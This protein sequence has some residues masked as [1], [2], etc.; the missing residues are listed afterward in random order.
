MYNR[1]PSKLSYIGQ[2]C[3]PVQTVKTQIKML[4]PCIIIFGV[5]LFSASQ[6]LMLKLHDL[7]QFSKRQMLFFPSFPQKKTRLTF[8]T[9]CLLSNIFTIVCSRVYG[10]CVGWCVKGG[11]KKTQF[12]M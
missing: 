7:D 3:L 9:D 1:K 5:V 11:D 2:T 8:L 6:S 10:L 12:G 4:R